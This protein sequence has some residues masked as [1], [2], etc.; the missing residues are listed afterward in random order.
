ME[1]HEL[2]TWYVPTPWTLATAYYNDDIFRVAEETE[3]L[4]S[5]GYT[6]DTLKEAVDKEISTRYITNKYR[7]KRFKKNYK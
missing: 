4:L 7:P 2:T 1:K 6:E 5:N 3:Y